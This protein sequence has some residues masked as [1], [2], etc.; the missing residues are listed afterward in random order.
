MED[1]VKM[2]RRVE[3]LLKR[4][5]RRDDY[6][7]L[8][9][10]GQAIR[11]LENVDDPE[12]WRAVIRRQAR[13]DRIKVRTGMNGHIVWALLSEGWTEAREAES[14]RYTEVLREA[15]PHAV[16]H[17]HEPMLAVR[18]GEEALLRCE[19]CEALG[20][21]DAGAGPLIGGPLFEDE[22]PHDAPPKLTALALSY[23]GRRL[24]D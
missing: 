22:C 10:S 12:A 23:G 9:A 11:R 1:P 8:L 4:V 13:A 21:G 24:H 18:D 15:V 7:Q 19:R 17:R 3:R 16:K 6:G 20:Y 14:D 2:N 5:A